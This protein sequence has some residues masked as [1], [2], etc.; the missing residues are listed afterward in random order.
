[1]IDGVRKGWRP[2]VAAVIAAG[3]LALTGCAESQLAVHVAK[4]ASHAAQPTPRE[5]KIH[6]ERVRAASLRPYTINNV[7]YVPKDDPKYDET[8]L[9]SWYGE[10]F[11]GRLTAA[12]EI[13]DMNRVSAAHKTLPL[14]T[15]VEVTNLE[16]GRV[17]V[18][19]VNDRGP[20]V[21]GRI[22]DLSRRAAQ[23]LGFE[24]DG[25]ARVRVR[26][27]GSPDD[28][29]VMR[30]KAI[31]VAEE[32]SVT[33]APRP[34]VQV[35]A[36]APPDAA[37]GASAMSLSTPA[38]TRAPAAPP[39]MLPEQAAAAETVYRVPVDAATRLFVQAGAFTDY[40]NAL[41]MKA[42]LSPVGGVDIQHALID[43]RDFYRVRIGPLGD[44]NEA[45][46]AL[47]RIKSQGA[48]DARIIVD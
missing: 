31:T 6:A 44:V 14:P 38:V 15:T 1:M 16:N 3:V 28:A 41:R 17:L 42:M 12:G 48:G 45:D 13:Y 32:K 23:L 30:P 2:A 24:R 9:A 5:R 35:A 19:R 18:V 40:Q 33:A 27:K 47:A 7:R 34:T 37:E 4:K 22:I 11:H 46:R 43:D 26:I 10:P 39:D 20:F 21:D 8:G 25:V 29:F 36:L